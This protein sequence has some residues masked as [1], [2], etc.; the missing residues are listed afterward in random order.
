M[1]YA[2]PVFVFGNIDGWHLLAMP[3]VFA[4]VGTL[5]DN[6]D[7]E[8]YRGFGKLSLVFGRNDGPSLMATLWAGNDFKHRTVQLDLNLPIRTRL[9]NFETYL[10]IQYFNGFGESLLSYDQESETVRAGISLVR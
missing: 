3:E 6:P 4:Y 10:L 9:L 8:K 7:L 5:E 2:R 1:L